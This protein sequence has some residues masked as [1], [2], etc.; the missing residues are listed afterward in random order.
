MTRL[1]GYSGTGVVRAFQ[2]AGWKVVRKKGSHVCMEKPGHESILTIPVHKGKD[3]KKGTLRNLI[4]D[5][6]MTVDE[7]L[8]CI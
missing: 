7:F 1:G 5:A 3:V 4:K 2:S 8:K 6:E